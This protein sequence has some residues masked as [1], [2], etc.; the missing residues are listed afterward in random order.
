MLGDNVLLYDGNEFPQ[1][2]TYAQCFNMFAQDMVISMRYKEYKP[3]RQTFLKVFVAVKDRS[4]F[5]EILSR[6]EAQFEVEYIDELPD[7][8]K[9]DI[10]TVAKML[11]DRGFTAAF[12]DIKAYRRE[13]EAQA[14][15]DAENARK[16]EEERKARER[17]RQKL[18][19]EEAA[20][21]FNDPAPEV[22]LNPKVLKPLQRR[23]KNA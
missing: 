4:K 5:H 8:R 21:I 15:I 7:Y 10:A 16:A 9:E 23:R 17:A 11:H 20:G 6:H 13:A 1:A 12:D 22:P 19:A 2:V 18:E 3:V 14:A